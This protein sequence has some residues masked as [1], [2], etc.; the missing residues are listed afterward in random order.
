MN[1][2]MLDLETLGNGN[3][4]VIAAIGAVKFDKETGELG[5]EFYKIV[6]PKT[7][8]D[9]G[10]IMDVDTVLWWFKQSPEAR[11]IFMHNASEI[12]TLQEALAEF[13]DFV[14]NPKTALVWGNGSNFDNVI[15]GNAYKAIGEPQPWPYWGDR[16]Y[17]TAAALTPGIKRNR[18]GT[19]HNALDDAKTQALHLM[20]ILRGSY[21]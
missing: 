2:I 13:T 17:R 11:A 4:A 15:L 20:Q 3:K 8:I 1:N 14:G 9:A 19:Y 21:E 18:V 12:S 6:N 16:C 5:Q 10:L 7:C